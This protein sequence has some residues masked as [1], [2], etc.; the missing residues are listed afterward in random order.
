MTRSL[1]LAAVALLVFAG[2][3]L[4]GPQTASGQDTPTTGSLKVNSLSAVRADGITT[5]TQS[6]TGPYTTGTL[7][8]CV[9]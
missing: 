7:A 2:A 3:G 4:F 6:R 8:D 5:T 9:P 1:M